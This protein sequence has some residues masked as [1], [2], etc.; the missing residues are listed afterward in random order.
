MVA[1]CNY[2]QILLVIHSFWVELKAGTVLAPVVCI[3][4]E[5]ASAQA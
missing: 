1:N 4:K 3:P 2:T 5:K